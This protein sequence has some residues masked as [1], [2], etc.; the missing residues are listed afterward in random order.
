MGI[1]RGSLYKAFADKRS[2]F[3]AALAHYDRT[4]V[5]AAVHVLRDAAAG[6]G[7]AR[8]GRVLQSVVAAVAKRGD[9]RGCFLCNTAVDQAPHDPE[10]ERVVKAMLRRFDR[11]FAEA[12]RATGLAA[13]RTAAE[14]GRIAEGLTTAYLGLRVRAKAGQPPRQLARTVATIL[15]EAG[16]QAA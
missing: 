11:A 12:L 8:I 16:L 6:D 14:L 7:A 13:D 9:R 1:T 4:E 3:L 2:L 15:G 10:V 5:E